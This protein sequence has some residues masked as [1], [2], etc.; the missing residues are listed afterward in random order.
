MNARYIKRDFS[1]P[2]S[3]LK[4]LA[5]V[6]KNDAP[7]PDSLF[8]TMWNACQDIAVDVL[9]TEYFQGIRRG[10]L[11]PVAYGT[12][13]VQDAYYC[14]KGRDDYSAATAHALDET[15]RAFCMGKCESYDSYNDYYHQIWHLREAD[16]VIPGAEIKSYA[17]YEAYVAGNLDTP[18]LFCVMLP[19]EYLWYWVATQL[20][21]DV[22]PSNLYRFWVDSNLSDDGPTGAYQMGNLLESYRGR[23]DEKQAMGIYQQAMR[24]ELSVFTAA[25]NLPD[26][27]NFSKEGKP[28]L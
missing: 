2:Q 24:H 26:T 13:A 4:R 1:I 16:G 20:D 14:F 7:P 15:C 27:A 10:D 6:L 23:I 19:C 22:S 25:T 11:D 17:D 9:N 5:L 12:L 3:R 18:Y 8:W 21:K 28:W